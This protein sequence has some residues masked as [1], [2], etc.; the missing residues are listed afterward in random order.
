MAGGKISWRLA[1]V[2][3]L[4]LAAAALTTAVT[5]P[6][7]A[8][9]FDDRFPFLFNRHNNNGGSFFG[10]PDDR[11]PT[12]HA[13]PVV[14]NT[15]APPPTRKSD[16]EPLTSVI[17]LGDSLADWLAYGLE[18]AAADSPDIGILRR[19]RSYSGLIRIEVKNDP[20]GEYPDWPQA[21]RDMLAADKANFV[22]MMV[23]LND[24][25]P[26]REKAPTKTSTQAATA[27]KKDGEKKDG[28]KNEERDT[29]S[30]DAPAEAPPAPGEGEHIS[31]GMITYEFR[32]DKW[33]ELYIKRIDETIAALKAKN[34][35]VFWVGL[36]PVRSPKISADLSYLND[37]YRSRADKA[38]ITY[39]DTWDGFV[40]ESGRFVM[41]GPDFE[42]QTRRLRSAD[43][44][45]FTEA[46][47]RK[48]AHYV[49]REIQRALMANA[50]PVTLPATD[51]PAAAPQPAAPHPGAAIARPLAGPVIPLTTPAE[52]NE[53]AG[54]A[55]ARQTATDAIASKVLVR[56]EPNRVPAG[57][58]DDFVWPRRPVAAPGIDPVVATTT[59]PMTPM[60][61]FEPHQVASAAPSTTGPPAPA[62]PARRAPVR[63][64]AANPRSNQQAPNGYYNGYNN[65]YNNQQRRSIA[66]QQQPFFFPFFGR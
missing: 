11:R 46:G 22:V 7:A 34:V 32:S 8:Q 18:Q 4:A 66:P 57:R 52:A 56:G 13:A 44:V 33:T 3:L 37:L 27:A 59:V 42:G 17:V 47:A 9:Q 19:Y 58:A 41:S 12:P 55:N 24:R 21:A 25:R 63:Q 36:P 35:P 31:G 23:G 40:D 62:A 14:E 38:G 64:A 5:T 51:E 48:L 39:I 6:A 15:H 2:L 16:A 45:H 1:G 49:E 50:T 54:G 20:K 26:I 43:G 28:E 60:Q 10:F 61:P 30:N 65:G 53:L 29:A